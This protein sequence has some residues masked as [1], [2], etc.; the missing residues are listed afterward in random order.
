MNCTM[1][2]NMLTVVGSPVA[3]ALVKNVTKDGASFTNVAG[4]AVVNTTKY[5]LKTNSNNQ[6]ILVSTPKY[7]TVDTA[8]VDMDIIDYYCVGLTTDGKNLFMVGSELNGSK[9]YGRLIKFEISTKKL[10]VYN[11]NNSSTDGVYAG[12]AY[13]GNNSFYL[14]SSKDSNKTMDVVKY[15]LSS[16]YK[17][18]E[19][20][21]L[22]NSGYAEMLQDIFYDSAHGLFVVTNQ[23]DSDGKYTPCKNI[24]LLYD[25]KNKPSGNLRATSRFRVNLNT[26]TYKQYNLESVCIIEKRLVA[27]ANVVTQAG[28]SQDKFL[29][30]KGIEF[31]E[32]GTFFMEHDV[33][34][35]GKLGNKQLTSSEQVDPDTEGTV[36]MTG[37]QSLSCGVKNNAN[38]IQGLKNGRANSDP[39]KQYDYLFTLK[40]D[41]TVEWNK[42]FKYS[43]LSQC[44]WHGNSM[45]YYDGY[46]YIGCAE[47]EDADKYTIVKMDTSGT[48]KTRYTAPV[49]TMAVAGGYGTS[50]YFILM[51][52]NDGET[53]YD[54]VLKKSIKLR[55]LYLGTL[56]GSGSSAKF[57]V[58]EKFYF[59][60]TTGTNVTPG[61]HYMQDICYYK[62]YGL[63]VTVSLLEDKESGVEYRNDLVHINIDKYETITLDSGE[64]AKML[65]PD[66]SMVYKDRTIFSDIEFES[67]TIRETDG[68]MLVCANAHKWP[69]STGGSAVS[70]DCVLQVDGITFS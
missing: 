18:G 56:E 52:G 38:V 34:V 25:L 4:V 5:C 61:T 30:L 40:S 9:R 50:N 6:S 51:S 54:P 43:P 58:K 60:D 48:I 44:L 64:S 42:L 3:G 29:Y 28:A 16:G 11:L 19:G 14:I 27:V 13:C 68:K 23:K 36:I 8:I 47:P 57:V 37:A 55:M 67:P 49:R 10:T 32:R 63:F 7:K 45:N 15:N 26:S 62:N 69:A 17:S 65:V 39:E 66:F 31:G 53:W 33:T 20:F 59:K 2:N 21:T 12:I 70:Y 22:V 24:V 35:L 41:N 46:Y 1:T